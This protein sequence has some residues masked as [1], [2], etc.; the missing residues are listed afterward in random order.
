MGRWHQNGVMSPRGL[1]SPTVSNIIKRNLKIKKVKWCDEETFQEQIQVHHR[2]DFLEEYSYVHEN[3]NKL[4]QKIQ[5]KENRHL[6]GA[7]R[8]V[9]DSYMAAINQIFL[10][11]VSVQKWAEALCYPYANGRL[12]PQTVDD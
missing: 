7:A 4:L 9:L 10:M 11:I 6:Q 1:M 2:Y 5:K 12:P 8:V 3:I